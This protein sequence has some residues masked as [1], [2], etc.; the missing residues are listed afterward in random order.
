M[1]GVSPRRFPSPLRYPGG[2]GKVA[3]YVKL[4]ILEN[5]LVGYEYVEPYAG[6]ASVA[7]SLLFEEYVS[8]IH[9][10]DIDRGVFTFWKVLLARPDELCKKIRDTSVTSW[11]W[12]RQRKV[13]LQ[14]A[15]GEVDD[16]DLAF[17]TFFLNRTNRSGIILGGPIGGARQTGRWKL[18][19][20]YNKRDL[21]RRIQ[22]IAR[23]ADR[24][25]VSGVDAQEFL[26]PWVERRQ[27]AFIY[28][29]PPYY[30][31][32]ADLYTNYYSNEDHIAISDLVRKL[33]AP[34]MVSYDAEPAIVELYRR[35]QRV[36]YVLSYSAAG[37]YRGKEIVFFSARLA[38]PTVSSPAN[39]RVDVV[40]RVRLAA[41]H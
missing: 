27:R 22:K 7:L 30:A 8:H 34:W 16:L 17:S 24:I 12:R 15:S 35:Y 25:S 32:G 6:G 1:G 39:I 28:L 38:P 41:L 31:R 9:I 20:R 18:D 37:R 10:N 21:T 36:S 5:D 13:Q 3:N 4:V 26:V 2:K 14:A 33:K 11:Q 19:A 40:D 23:F 29:D